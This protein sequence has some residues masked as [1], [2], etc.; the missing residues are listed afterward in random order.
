MAD[1]ANLDAELALWW[2]AG[3]QPT[4]WWRDDDT[5]APTD[6]LDQLIGLS[7]RFSVPLHLAVVPHD[8]GVGLAGCLAAAKGVFVMQH[9]FAHL[10]HE[11]KGTGAS[12]IGAT[13]D[14]RLQ[15][16][17]LIEGWERL[18]AANLPR[19][20]PVLVPPWNRIGARTMQALPG[21]GYEMLSTYGP[22]GTPQVAGLREVNAHVDPVRWKE[23]AVCRGTNKTLG[24]V[25]DHLSARRLGSVDLTEPTGLL[26][27]HLQTDAATWE[28]VEALLD[29]LTP[30]TGAQ[31]VT[32]ASMLENS[33]NG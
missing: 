5:R 14:L 10:N 15:R 9:G 13:R 23:G 11:P 25:V 3:R 30:T 28:F 2:T 19:L 8:I 33:G 4:F 32:L 20:L 22:R 12:E 21:L 27:H 17:D 26:T 24:Q 6:D 31:W 29:R 18:V 7:E 16:A 1:W